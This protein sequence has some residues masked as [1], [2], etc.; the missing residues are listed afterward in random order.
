MHQRSHLIRWMHQRPPYDIIS[1]S[2]DV[3]DTTVNA[4]KLRNDLVPTRCVGT[5]TYRAAVLKAK[6]QRALIA[7]PRSAWEREEKYLSG[8]T[9]K[10]YHDPILTVKHGN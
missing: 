5:P 1:Q 2:H 6:A 9:P 7:F 8:G 4:I 10:K 3:D